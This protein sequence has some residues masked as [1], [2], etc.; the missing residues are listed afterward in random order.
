MEAI[1]ELLLKSPA[2]ERLLL[3]ATGVA[4]SDE[5]WSK[6]FSTLVDGRFQPVFMNKIYLNS[7]TRCLENIDFSLWDLQHL[8][9]VLVQCVPRWGSLIEK[10]SL[11]EL[12]GLLSVFTRRGL[13]IMISD[14]PTLPSGFVDSIRRLRY[15]ILRILWYSSAISTLFQLLRCFP[16]EED[17]SV[18]NNLLENHKADE[19]R[20]TVIDA[21]EN[22]IVCISSLVSVVKTCNTHDSSSGIVQLKSTL[23][24]FILAGAS[25][26]DQSSCPF[27]VSLCS[28]IIGSGKTKPPPSTVNAAC[29]CLSNILE[30]FDVPP[31]SFISAPRFRK[32]NERLVTALLDTSSDASIRLL[33][34]IITQL[35]SIVPLDKKVATLIQENQKMYSSA[36]FA[37]ETFSVSDVSESPKITSGTVYML[38]RYLSEKSSNV[39]SLLTKSIASSDWIKSELLPS[40][41]SVDLLSNFYSF[42][43]SI[44]VDPSWV[45][46]ANQVHEPTL[47]H[48]VYHATSGSSRLDKEQVAEFNSALS[49]Y[50]M[51]QELLTSLILLWNRFLAT[52]STGDIP[53]RVRVAI[54]TCLADMSI[55]DENT[56]REYPEVINKLLLI[57]L[58]TVEQEVKTNGIA[59]SRSGTV[60]SERAIIVSA[61]V[62]IVPFARIPKGMDCFVTGMR[63][64]PH[65]LLDQPDDQPNDDLSLLL[66]EVS[67]WVPASIILRGSQN[68]DPIIFSTMEAMVQF[69]AKSPSMVACNRT[70]FEYLETG[71]DCMGSLRT[72]SNPTI[73]VSWL[74]LISSIVVLQE[75]DSLAG[76]FVEKLWTILACHLAIQALASAPVW[77]ND[78]YTI[79]HLAWVYVLQ[80]STVLLPYSSSSFGVEKFFTTYKSRLTTRFTTAHTSDLASIEEACLIA[81]LIEAA[82]MGCLEAGSPLES[83]FQ[84]TSLITYK[85]P[86]IY[87]RSRSEKIGGNLESIMFEDV[88]MACTVP[89]VFA[90]RI[91]WLATDIVS[92]VVRRIIRTYSSRAL[93]DDSASVLFHSLLDCSH[94]VTQYLKE[95]SLHEQ[96]V[97]RLVDINES[98][99]VPLSVYIQPGE[100]APPDT[101][102]MKEKAKEATSAVGGASGSLLN[103]LPSPVT[104]ATVAPLQPRGSLMDSLSPKNSAAKTSASKSVVFYSPRSGDCPQ[105]AGLSFIAPALVT[106]DDFVGKLIEVLSLCLIQAMRLATTEA[107]VRPLLDLLMSMKS[108]AD[109]L[110]VEANGLVADL[111]DI[112]APRYNSFSEE[113]RQVTTHQPQQSQQRN[114]IYPSIG[115]ITY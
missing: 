90:Q 10:G 53:N 78:Q 103:S 81:R 84:F 99:Y 38:A 66:E 93:G 114:P 41:E 86:G 102:V 110:P 12:C 67:R 92:S 113:R 9:N 32:L 24:D 96:N 106:R 11:D 89:C 88:R 52:N 58:A 60:Q 112:V 3:A 42:L 43:Q 83:P 55:I 80:L 65:W 13:C 62:R 76:S 48:F 109:K 47:S 61:L 36:P 17:D 22:A 50:T 5:T 19:A 74:S 68:S 27:L 104:K 98:V 101:A 45:I 37:A 25:P 94:F 108:N 35:P 14:D 107:L 57:L 79:E 21:Q 73:L 100:T 28:F 71:I 7:L 26:S 33:S 29:D 18:A 51:R 85:P 8:E 95:L 40:R 44:R 115:N 16:G 31:S 6:L 64:L 20:R 4:E 34:T 46:S 72:V 15:E 77:A 56:I 97:L 2:D 49:E 105:R 111:V 91:V 59:L 1:F 39:E 75:D 87:P 54:L 70:V 30:A 82:P 23:S 63:C 69:I